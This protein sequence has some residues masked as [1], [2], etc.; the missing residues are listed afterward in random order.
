MSRQRP[1]DEE[2]RQEEAEELRRW[3]FE[4]GHV[5]WGP[6]WIMG[7]LQS[8]AACSARVIAPGMNAV[9]LS[10]ARL[11][12]R[13]GKRSG[14]DLQAAQESFNNLCESIRGRLRGTE[15]FLMMDRTILQARRAVR[16]E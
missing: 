2:D 13:E 8:G 1:I 3:K 16:D 10:P 12:F 15:H 9:N 11:E 4:L 5:V 14:Q 7:C 6:L